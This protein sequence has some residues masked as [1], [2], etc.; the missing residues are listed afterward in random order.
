MGS[1]ASGEFF[2]FD[3][4]HSRTL[5]DRVDVQ[6]GG[7]PGFTAA[8]RRSGSSCGHLCTNTSCVLVVPV[9]GMRA[10]VYCQNPH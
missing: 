5:L 6:S 3:S 4:G 10:F 8:T 7:L 9:L 2:F 1:S